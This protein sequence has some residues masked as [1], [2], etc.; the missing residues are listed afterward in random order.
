MQRLDQDATWG[1]SGD[2]DRFAAGELAAVLRCELEDEHDVILDLSQ[3]TLIDS[4]SLGV[5]LGATKRAP[6]RGR[7]FALRTNASEPVMHV[8]NIGGT[9]DLFDWVGGDDGLTGVRE[10]R[11]PRPSSGQSGIA[12][13]PE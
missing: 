1:V 6:R 3:V 2:L 9:R 12:D 13:T 4:T 7:R 10:R 11:R 8:L 5:L